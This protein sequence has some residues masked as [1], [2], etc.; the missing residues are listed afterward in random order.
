MHLHKLDDFTFDGVKAS[1]YNVQMQEPFTLAG[2]V[3]SAVYNKKL[4]G[5][6]GNLVAWDKTYSNR[7][8]TAKCY[9]LDMDANSKMNAFLNDIF[10]NLGYRKL[11]VDSIPGVYLMALITAGPDTQIRNGILNPFQIQFSCKPQKFLISGDQEATYTSTGVIHNPTAFPAKPLVTVY[12][13]GSGTVRIGATTVKILS[14][15]DQITLDCE[16]MDAYRQ[17]EDGPR[18]NKNS[19]ISAPVFPALKAGSNAISWTGGITGVS[20]IPR[21]WRL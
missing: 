20:I 3:F 10:R 8:G 1:D 5:R 21:W 13:S 19:C 7:K 18:E 12:G 11:Y 17:V 6:N 9:L 15:K 4:V 2:A 14:I 16:L